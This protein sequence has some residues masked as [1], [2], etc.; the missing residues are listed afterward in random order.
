MFFVFEIVNI[1][2]RKPGPPSVTKAVP[3]PAK[4][5]SSSHDGTAFACLASA[6]VAGCVGASVSRRCA[7]AAVQVV[8][9][10][11]YYL[12]GADDAVVVGRASTPVCKVPSS[13]PGMAPGF[14]DA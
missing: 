6:I 8:D 14:L 4:G 11:V 12:G 7:T 1:P 2:K 3:E 13:W 9:A 5:E 10:H